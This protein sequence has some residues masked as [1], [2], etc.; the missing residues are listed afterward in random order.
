MTS[1]DQLIIR[2]NAVEKQMIAITGLADSAKLRP[3]VMHVISE[4]KDNAIAMKSIAY[5]DKELI[6][7][8]IDTDDNISD[9]SDSNINNLKSTNKK[10]VTGYTEFRRIM[11]D[12]AVN[13]ICEEVEAKG[14][15]K[16]INST[17]K[18]YLI[19]KKLAAM[20]KE[21]EPDDKAIWNA[22]ADKINAE[23]KKA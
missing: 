18:Q 12:D 20:W 23:I 4:K 21:I 10:R 11:R 17:P 8:A 14:E 3:K 6:E 1:L 2:I 13:A 5:P 19:L 9:S 15:M 22:E 16:N 7:E